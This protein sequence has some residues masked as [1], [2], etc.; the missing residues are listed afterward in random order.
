MERASPQ[1]S[2][3]RQIAYCKYSNCVECGSLAGVEPKQAVVKARSYQTRADVSPAQLY[4]TMLNDQYVTRF[5]NPSA[6]YISALTG[7]DL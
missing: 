4:S 2:H 3:V 1:C 5:Y 6:A 7:R